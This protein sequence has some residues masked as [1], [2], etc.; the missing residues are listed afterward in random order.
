MALSSLSEKVGGLPVWEWVTGGVT[1]VVGA[2]FLLHRKAATTQQ[3][4]Q[5]IPNTGAFGNGGGGSGGSGTLTCPT[6]FTLDPT[7]T[8]CIPITITPPPDT[9]PTEADLITLVADRL[10][11]T[12][13]SLSQSQ[14]NT[15]ATNDV[16]AWEAAVTNHTLNFPSIQAMLTAYFNQL[17]SIG[18]KDQ[19]TVPIVPNQ[20][21]VPVSPSPVIPVMASHN[22]LVPFVQHPKNAVF[23]RGF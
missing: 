22:Q 8:T 16:R 3:A 2:Y 17:T 4:V 14:A 19:S 15:Y 21:N 13:P 6:G 23:P 7:G 1:L 20:P 10:L 12:Q 9:G 11:N 18:T 5:L